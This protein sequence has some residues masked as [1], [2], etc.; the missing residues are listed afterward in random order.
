MKSKL[1]NENEKRKLPFWFHY[2]LK[3]SKT[4]PLEPR[5][6]DQL[7]VGYIPSSYFNKT[8]N[9]EETLYSL[10][11]SYRDTFLSSAQYVST[12]D[13]TVVSPEFLMERQL[14]KNGLDSSNVEYTTYGEFY[15]D[16][17]QSSIKAVFPLNSTYKLN[18]D[19]PKLVLNLKERDF[20]PILKNEEKVYIDGINQY[21]KYEKPVESDVG[22]IKRDNTDNYISTGDAIQYV[23]KYVAS[24]INSFPIYERNENN[25]S[26]FIKETLMVNSSET[27]S[28]IYLNV[29]RALAGFDNKEYQNYFMG[30][31]LYENVAYKQFH[32]DGTFTLMNTDSP[33]TFYTKFKNTTY[34]LFEILNGKI[35]G[36]TFKSIRDD[37][38]STDKQFYKGYIE[39]E[40]KQ[41]LMV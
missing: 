13:M 4:I 11:N 41:L 26:E 31:Y 34:N 39:G 25:S 2:K 21:D 5:T 8:P 14:I 38:N 9:N 22:L 3:N 23:H 28:Y 40:K 36:K 15:L 24:S 7:R 12:S 30:P 27:P 35:N 16:G 18:V 37:V 20:I 1:K 10:V 32:N 6:G 17:I 33:L 29:E 19:S